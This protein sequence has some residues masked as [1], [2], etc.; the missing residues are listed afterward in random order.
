M[1]GNGNIWAQITF[2]IGVLAS[3]AL[4]IFLYENYDRPANRR[5]C[6]SQAGV[7]CLVHEDCDAGHVCIGEE[8]VGL[9]AWSR[10]G[11][12]EDRHGNPLP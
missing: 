8:C 1:D 10:T 5:V 7:Q 4:C 6:L 11:V 12:E 9:I 3:G 2:L